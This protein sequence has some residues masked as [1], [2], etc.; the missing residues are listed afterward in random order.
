MTEPTIIIEDN[1]LAAGP[2]LHYVCDTAERL[3][4]HE[5][6]PAEHYVSGFFIVPIPQEGAPT[7]AFGAVASTRDEAISA[8]AESWADG[9]GKHATTANANPTAIGSF[10]MDASQSSAGAA[11]VKRAE[12]YTRRFNALGQRGDPVFT[13]LMELAGHCIMD[14]MHLMG[15]EEFDEYCL[16]VING[17]IGG[18]VRARPDDW[19]AYL[20]QNAASSVESFRSQLKL[21][22]T[23]TDP[24]RAN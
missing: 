4:L 18:Y 24:S 12:E 6:H 8:L 1:L 17:A 2:S 21:D 9:L 23:L 7:L 16:T 15:V 22:E 3:R 19:N 14:I 11:R 13:V 20:Q 10:Q 5:Q